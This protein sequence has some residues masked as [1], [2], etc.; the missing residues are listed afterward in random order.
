M[1]ARPGQP[2][3]GAHEP[4]AQLEGAGPGQ[5]DRAPAADDRYPL[6]GPNTP[7]APDRAGNPELKPELAT[8]IDLALEHY[9]SG[10]GVFSASLFHRRIRDL[11]RTVTALEDVA[12]SPVPRWVSRTRNI[13]EATTQG[14][15][16]EAKGRA[17]Q[18]WTGAPRTELRASL[19][20]FR[21]RVDGLPGPDNRLDE[22]ADGTLNL[23]ADHA[24]R[25][26]P[27]KGGVNLNWVP[28]YRT[29]L[30]ETQ[31]VQV[32]DRRVLDLYLLWT[33]QPGLAWRLSAGNVLPRDSE[34]LRDYDDGSVRSSVRSV[35]PSDIA[36]RLQLEL[37]L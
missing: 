7:T 18:W 6:D 4:H 36:W 34:N 26:T 32:D 22:Q 2:Q 19:S 12:W 14:V 37:K 11:Q 23:G 35:T 15:E 21:S 13:G 29:Q 31:W 1:E 17:D 27:L 24:W 30:S 20:L 16:L 9:P 33:V 3:P 25:G 8:G 10:G 5:P 28:G